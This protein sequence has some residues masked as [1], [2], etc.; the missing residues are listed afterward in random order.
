[1]AGTSGVGPCSEGTQVCTAASVWGPCEGEIVP[2][3]ED[4]T[5]G[6]DNNCNGKLDEDEDADGDGFMTC[7]GAD[8]C[9]STECA[10]PATSNPGLFDDPTNLVDDDCNGV[11]DDLPSC[12][13]GL[14]SDS[15]VAF[16]YAKAIDL[17]PTTAAEDPSWGV[18]DARLTLAD[19]MGAPAAISHSIRARFGDNV[20]PGRGTSMMV[21]STGAAAGKDDTKPAYQDFDFTATGTSSAFPAD[22]LAANNGTLPSAP[23]CPGLSGT[24]ANDPVMLTLTIRVPTNA[25]SFTL[26]TSFFSAEYPEWTC[27]TYNDFFVVLLDSSYAGDPANPPDKNLAV[28]RAN[29]MS[30]PVGVNLA[31]GETGLFSQCR[32]GMLGCAGSSPTTTQSCTGID[33]LVNTGFD[34]PAPGEC[35]DDSLKG[36]GTG[37]LHTSGNVVPGELITLR[38]AIWDTGDEAYDSLAVIDA[39]EWSTQ[40]TTAGTVLY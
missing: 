25:Q 10:A 20:V 33:M 21:I 24:T 15:D 12:D 35:D 32:N 3:A 5:D 18:L 39:F 9:D 8:C 36:G 23:A 2:V 11:A 28:H 26:R 27:S 1:M 37:W 4:C 38:I 6:V 34:D 16:D 7:S 19:G 14:A 17:C 13:Q 31:N 30:Y 22:F 40:P 29:G